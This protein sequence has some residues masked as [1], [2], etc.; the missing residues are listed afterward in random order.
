MLAR[1][2][3]L[4]TLACAAAGCGPGRPAR[5]PAPRLDPAA[6]TAAVFAAADADGDGAL[7][8]EEWTKVPALVAAAAVLDTNG[9]KRLSRDE[10]AKWLEDVRASKV[11]ITSFAAQVM[12][13]GK[14]LADATVKLIPETFMGS[15]L[16]AA[17][18]KTD[19]GGSV[20]VT[21]PDSKYPGVHCGLYRV[22][23]VG[24]GTDGKP[25]PAKFNAESMLGVA[26]GGML[27]ENGMV[28][29]ELD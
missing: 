13:K 6:V 20:L 10:L 18:G 29:F 14:P 9:D 15:E 8:G 4:V 26:V 25:L 28:L 12:H 23:I 5:V 11:A 2:T 19:A 21:I 16:K 7:G 3:L 17:E 1:Q 24:N 27:P 22:E